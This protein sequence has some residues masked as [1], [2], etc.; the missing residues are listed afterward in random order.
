MINNG[1]LVIPRGRG[2]ALGSITI[3]L[4]EINR[5]EGRINEVS[6]ATPMAMGEL[7]TEFNVGL[8][9]LA[10]AISMVELEKEDAKMVMKEARAICILDK[11]DDILKAKGQKSSADMREAVADLD[12]DVKEATSRYNSLRVVSEYLE[13]RKHAMELAYHAAKKVCDVHLKLPESKNFGG[14]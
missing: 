9:H 6:R 7:I 2:A 3:D 4:G 11:A 8:L 1:T 10:R 13:S 5:I 14:E 12:A